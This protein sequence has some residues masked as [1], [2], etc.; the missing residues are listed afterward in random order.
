MKKNIDFTIDFESLGLYENSVLLSIGAAKFDDAEI[1]GKTNA[2]IFDGALNDGFQ[3]KLDVKD[4]L[5]SGRK[6]DPDTAEWWKT[7]ESESAKAVLKPSISD[8]SLDLAIKKFHEYLQFNGFS[9]NS[10]IWGRG[11]VEPMW[12]F[13]ICKQYD[14]D[15]MVK[16]WQFRDARTF[17][18]TEMHPQRFPKTVQP[19]NFIPHNALHDSAFL[20]VTMIDPLDERE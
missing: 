2:D 19:T 20:I 12:Y 6:I 7:Q 10:N 1:E 13:A 16:Y 17:L 5:R 3:L 8:A 18:Y 15:P 4:Q 9:R 14:I 11:Y